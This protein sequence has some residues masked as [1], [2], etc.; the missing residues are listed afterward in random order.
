M[1]PWLFRPVCGGYDGA[2]NLTDCERL[3]PVQGMC[4]CHGVWTVFG[5][6]NNYV[7]PLK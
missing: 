6:R 3:D 4:F 2:Q 5:G 7:V 1:L